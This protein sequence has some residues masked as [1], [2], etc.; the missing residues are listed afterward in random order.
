M[1]LVD[2]VLFVVGGLVLLELLSLLVLVAVAA[3]LRG[4]AA[5]LRR[6]TLALEMPPL[7]IAGPPDVQVDGDLIRRLVAEQ[8]GRA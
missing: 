1:R 2:Q 7:E 4:V 8:E 5:A 6:M 3:A